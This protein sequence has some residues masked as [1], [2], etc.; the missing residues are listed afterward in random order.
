[1]PPL[2]DELRTCSPPEEVS[3][4]EQSYSNDFDATSKSEERGNG[5]WKGGTGEGRK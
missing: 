1:M 3:A 5:F 2:G 4:E